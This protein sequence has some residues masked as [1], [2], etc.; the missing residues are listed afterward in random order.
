MINFDKDEII[1]EFGISPDELQDKEL[2]YSV[3][4]CGGYTG[5][6]RTIYRDA[7]GVLWENTADHCSCNSLRDQWGPGV[8]T[9]EALKMRIPHL[10]SVR[11]LSEENRYFLSFLESL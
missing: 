11:Y 9:V 10:K 5:V 6:A 1:S 7:D 3:Y 4:S 2:L 8:V